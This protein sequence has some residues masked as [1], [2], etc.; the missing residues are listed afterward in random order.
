MLVPL[1][2]CTRRPYKAQNDARA[3][4]VGIKEWRHVQLYIAYSPAD[5]FPRA[6]KHLLIG[7]DINIVKCDR[8]NLKS[9]L[10]VP[11]QDMNTCT[12]GKTVKFGK[13]KMVLR[14]VC[15]HIVRV[16]A[17]RVLSV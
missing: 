14:C 4:A 16:Y 1:Y 11:R 5:C 3:T 15:V 12:H 6:T 9:C 8:K 2:L 17:H 7:T 10:A 13:Q